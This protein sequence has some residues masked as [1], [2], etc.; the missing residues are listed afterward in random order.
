MATSPDRASRLAA[1]RSAHSVRE[2]TVGGARWAYLDAGAGPETLVVLPGGLRLAE[3]AFDIIEALAGERRII[4]PDYP[5]LATLE[6]LADGLAG[7]LAQLGAVRVD[8]MGSSLGGMVAQVFA[9]RHSER[10][11]RLILVTTFPPRL[12][13]VASLRR[14]RRLV[15]WLPGWLLRR[16]MTRAYQSF[17]TPSPADKAFWDAYMAEAVATR[18]T[19]ADFLATQANVIDFHARYRFAP[20]ELGEVEGRSLVLDSDDDPVVTLDEREALRAL[21]PSASHRRLAGA[22][23]T[24]FLSQPEPAIAA[25]RAFL[26]ESTG[27]ADP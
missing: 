7:L 2:A 11:H 10:L 23:H 25:L 3:P 1:F 15:S 27:G 20:G 14:Q 19:R 12:E 21:Y 4:V 13:R 8:L 16:V 22:G 17:T 6:A 18:L 9:R 24:M 5:P 26:G